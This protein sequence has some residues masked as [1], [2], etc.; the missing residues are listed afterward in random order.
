ML[1]DRAGQR[2]QGQRTAGQEA[3]PGGRLVRLLHRNRGDN[4][5]VAVIPFPGLEVHHRAHTGQGAVGGN[6]QRRL[7]GVSAF[8]LERHASRR[9]P[10]AGLEGR[11]A[12]QADVSRRA[13]PL[14]QGADDCPVLHDVPSSGA[15]TSDWSNSI[16]PVPSASHTVM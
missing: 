8:Q 1:V 9:L 5:A 16:W 3:L 14:Q 10:C 4:R 6:H 11:R 2:Q 15:S 13:Y 7:Q 12:E